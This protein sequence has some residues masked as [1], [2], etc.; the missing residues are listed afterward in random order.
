MKTLRRY[1]TGEFLVTCLMGLAILT[2]VMSIGVVF[3]AT[4]LLGRGAAWKPILSLMASG[5]PATLTFSVP[6]ALLTTSLLLF[7]RLS[8]DGEITA[9]RSCG[10]GMWRIMSGPLVI[11]VLFMCLCLYINSV[12]GPASHYAR[13][14]VRASL[15]QI[16]PLDLLEEGRFVQDFSG[17][18]IY[19][20]QR[21][22]TELKDVRIYDLRKKGIRREVRAKTGNVTLN[23]DT[24]EV[25]ITLRDVRIDPFSDDRPGAMY[26]SIWPISIKDAWRDRVYRPRKKD[27]HSAELY[28]RTRHTAAFY[29]ELSIE[30]LAIERMELLVEQSKRLSLAFACVGFVILGIPLGMKTHRKESSIGMA[31][32]LFLVMNFYLFII[33]AESL[34]EKPAFRPDLIIW[35]PVVLSVWLGIILVRRQQ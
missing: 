26:A 22:G 5:M 24:R 27:F 28:V 25:L 3:K 31:I 33:V 29:P 18:T 8:A 1:I 11:A 9:M 7:G 12:V 6:I 21:H 13:K 32:S 19:I 2:F 23:T 35:I 14:N 4:T 15:V 16:N 20:G 30:D 17:L 10:I 34:A